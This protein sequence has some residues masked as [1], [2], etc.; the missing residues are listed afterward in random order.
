MA[1]KGGSR[2]TAIV[3]KASGEA[4]TTE[5]TTAVCNVGSV[6][7]SKMYFMPAQDGEGA[8]KPKITR[9]VLDRVLAQEEG[10]RYNVDGGSY[11]IGIS[12]ICRCGQK[13]SGEEVSVSLGYTLRTTDRLTMGGRCGLV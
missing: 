11:G 13:L 6:L 7:I 10:T 9:I 8:K 1:T 3:A 5:T 12:M 4:T 2:E